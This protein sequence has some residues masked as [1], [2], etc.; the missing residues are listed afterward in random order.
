MQKKK[1]NEIVARNLAELLRVTEMSKT[2]LSR[3]SGVSLRSIYYALSQERIVG[4]DT[5]DALARV[6]GLSGY[7]LQMPEFDFKAMKSGK[8]DALIK[9]Y[10]EG[11][12]D[13]RM[14][15]EAQAKYS[16]KKAASAND[17]GDTKKKKNGSDT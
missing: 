13:G 2:D 8:L 5:V 7:H 10:I 3:K 15:M 16:V 4:I 6:F 9:G 11:D 12:E 14:L 17:E 1:P